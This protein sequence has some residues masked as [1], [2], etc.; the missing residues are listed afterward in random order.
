MAETTETIIEQLKSVKISGSMRG[1]EWLDD[2]GLQAAQTAV[3]CDSAFH[4]AVAIT[5]KRAAV[6]MRQYKTTIADIDKRLRMLQ[7]GEC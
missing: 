4:E 1:P 3:E 7:S 5:L 6:E 2:L